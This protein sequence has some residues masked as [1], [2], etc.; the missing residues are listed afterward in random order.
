[1]NRPSWSG[2]PSIRARLITTCRAVQRLRGFEP[3]V[4]VVRIVRVK[5]RL[6]NLSSHRKIGPKQGPSGSSTPPSQLLA[7][8]VPHSPSPSPPPPSPKAPPGLRPSYPLHY[9]HR[10][11]VEDSSDMPSSS[12]GSSSSASPRYVLRDRQ[13]IRPP[14]RF[15][16]VTLAKLTS[17]HDVVVHQEWQ[18]AMAEEI[19]ALEHTGTWDL[20]PLPARATPITCK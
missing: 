11:R 4:F 14:A 16:L 12:D 20:V 7:S 2:H 3:C 5:R 19:A 17:Y 13:S 18:H 6:P 9:T 15:C 8:S 1:M 10:P